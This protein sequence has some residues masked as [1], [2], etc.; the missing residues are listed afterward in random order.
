MNE[1][2]EWLAGQRL[3]QLLHSFNLNVFHSLRM[4]RGGEVVWRGVGVLWVEQQSPT[5]AEWVL[6]SGFLWLTKI[7]SPA[8]GVGLWIHD[9]NGQVLH[10]AME[11]TPAPADH[12]NS[13]FSTK[14]NTSNE[15]YIQYIQFNLNK[16]KQYCIFRYMN[17]ESLH[18]TS[19]TEN[20]VYFWKLWKKQ[21]TSCNEGKS[22]RFSRL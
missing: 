2:M 10:T 9:G 19:I 11:G 22:C 18:Q 15:D 12:H 5:L 6:S 20:K 13:D 21:K 16:M 4:R 3:Q 14:K 17:M 1:W 8:V 7:L